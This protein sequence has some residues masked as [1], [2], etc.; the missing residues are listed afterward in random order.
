MQSSVYREIFVD[1]AKTL[2]VLLVI[3]TI[4]GEIPWLA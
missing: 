2:P 4:M 3:G 1:F